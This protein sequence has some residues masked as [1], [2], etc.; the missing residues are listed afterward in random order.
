MKKNNTFHYRWVFNGQ[1]HMDKRIYELGRS[2]PTAYSK[3]GMTVGVFLKTSDGLLVKSIQDDSEDSFNLVW[4]VL[5]CS[6]EENYD[7]K[8]ANKIALNRAIGGSNVLT[9]K[10]YDWETVK[11]ISQKLVDVTVSLSNNKFYNRNG[12]WEALKNSFD[13]DSWIDNGMES[14]N[15]VIKAGPLITKT[16][17][18]I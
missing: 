8:K 7:R 15:V 4:V 16:K 14:K 9:S 2:G 3:G 12:I 13:I 6:S 1:M 5:K 17:T 11:K 18:K 10:N